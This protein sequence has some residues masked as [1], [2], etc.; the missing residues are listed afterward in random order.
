[1]L[2]IYSNMQDNYDYKLVAIEPF[3]IIDNYVDMRL[4]FYV[5]M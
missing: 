5:K 1:M 3:N 4:F 2:L